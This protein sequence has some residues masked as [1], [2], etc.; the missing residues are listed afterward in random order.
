MD[1][2]TSLVQHVRANG[3]FVHDLLE[4]RDGDCGVRGVFASGVIQKDEELIFIPLQCLLV[5]ESAKQIPTVQKL[6]RSKVTFRHRGDILLA[7]MIL[8]DRKQGAEA[9]FSEFYATLPKGF[10]EM[11][12]FWSENEL[13]LLQGSS[14]LVEIQTKKVDLQYDYNAMCSVAEELKQFTFEEFEWVMCN[15][16]SRAFNV[17]LYGVHTAVMVPYLDLLNHNRPRQATYG[18]DDTRQVFF[19][20]SLQ[21]F[22]PGDQIH[23]TYGAVSNRK[24]L[25]NYGF[26]LPTNRWVV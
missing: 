13:R 5:A 21:A 20:K 22:Y 11:P 24:L 8:I 1:H 9:R 10:D 3:G 19:V 18:Y 15:I 4:C 17:K 25:I 23:I 14:I 12:L 7:C 2:V 6:I 16:S 26:V